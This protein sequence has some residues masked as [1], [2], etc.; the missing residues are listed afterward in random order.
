MPNPTHRTRLAAITQIALAC[1][2]LAMFVSTHVSGDIVPPPFPFA[3]KIIHLVA[4]AVLAALLATTWQVSAGYL[5]ARHLIWVWVI[6]AL[7]ALL[8]EW[9]QT[10]VGRQA[11]ALDWLADAAGAVLGLILFARLRR[12]NA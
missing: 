12:A 1:Y 6:V 3:D 10:F 5:T 11:S 4:H 9:T 2:W 7:Y 8:D